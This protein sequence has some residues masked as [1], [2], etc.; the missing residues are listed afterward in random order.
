MSF[1]KHKKHE[2][3]EENWLISYADMITLLICFFVILLSVMEKKQT[4]KEQVESAIQDAFTSSVRDTKTPFNDL[5]QNLQQVIEKDQMEQSVSLEETEKGMMLELSSSSFYQSGSATFKPEAIPVLKDIATTLNDFGAEDYIVKVEGH[6][7]DVPMKSDA[8][9]SNWEL[10]A[11]RA[12]TVVRFFIDSGQPKDKMK[13]EGLADTQPK[14]PNEDEYGNAIP[15]NRE[16]NRRIVI[17]IERRE[18]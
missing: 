11:V 2:E 3:I 5:M 13:A 7:D 8:F 14:V 4:Q 6:T 15:E 1:H 12:T 17:R 10:S 18:E 16:I 9:P